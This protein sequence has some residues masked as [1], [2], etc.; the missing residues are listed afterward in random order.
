MHLTTPH[1]ILSE[2]DIRVRICEGYSAVLIEV[3][4]SLHIVLGVFSALLVMSNHS[5]ANMK[6][7]HPTIQVTYKLFLLRAQAKDAALRWQYTAC[8]CTRVKT[9]LRM[10][11]SRCLDRMHTVS[12]WKL[13]CVKTLS[14][15]V[16]KQRNR[17]WRRV[18]SKVAP[19]SSSK[20]RTIRFMEVVI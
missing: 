3:R 20:I 4:A 11:L 6:R 14:P 13:E 19:V 15:L 9:L 10:V 2:T 1:Q 12:G 5:D 17:C 8:T 18:S 7:T 16:K